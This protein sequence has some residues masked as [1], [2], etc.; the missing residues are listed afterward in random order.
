MSTKKDVLIVGAGVA[1]PTLAYWLARFGF[2]PTVVE[3]TAA[4]RT[5]SHPVDLWGSAVDVV[6]QIGILPA[7]EAA[8][9]QN[10]RGET[11]S[12]G[13]QPVAFDLSQLAVSL[14][15]RHVEVMRGEL[16]SRLY[17]RT[18]DTV[19]YLFGTSITGLEEQ[20]D[21]VA[22]TFAHGPPRRF[23][24]V[25][26]ADGLHSQVRR[27]T[28]GEERAF[29]HDLGGFLAG[30]TIPNY[31]GLEGRIQRYVVPNKTVVV[32][33]IRASGKLGV[34]F[35]FRHGAM[36]GSDHH[37]AIQ[38][39]GLLRAIFGQDGWEVP[40]L[41]A[42]LNA[43]DDFYFDSI[44]QIR[45]P[46]WSRGRVTLVGDAGY[47]P[48]PAVGGGTTLAVVGAYVLAQ[49]LEEAGGDYASAFQRYERRLR[50][51]VAQSR[52]IG[53]AVMRTLIPQRQ[54]EITLG[55]RLLP[56]V[57]RLP[58]WLKQRV[59]LL[60]RDAARGLRAMA[61]LPLQLPEP[62]AR[63]MQTMAPPS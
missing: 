54:A 13:H 44:S 41:L 12:P 50:D 2:R 48:A 59:P 55:I 51:V 16:V 11:I 25:V 20:P 4:L 31:L 38:H 56:L 57:L 22:V 53:P 52:A 27:L 21:G 37:D 6:E 26:G 14:A 19:E 18:T 3:R 24:L 39:R 35:L 60:P 33:P 30:Y 42:H 62:G 15:G 17:E 9:T 32:F 1:G 34:L 28:F 43:A 8:R 49:A 61:E 40:R 46:S 10:D 47:A 36:P 45:M 23:A 5:G 7:I 58:A 63:P 29:R